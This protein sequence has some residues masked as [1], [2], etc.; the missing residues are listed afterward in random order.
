MSGRRVGRPSGRFE[1]DERNASVPCSLADS[2]ASHPDPPVPQRM[3]RPNDFVP[4]DLGRRP[5]FPELPSIAAE[6]LPLLVTGIA[7]VAGYQAFLA[8]RA[9]YGTAVFGQRRRDNRRLTGPGVLAFDLEDPV[10]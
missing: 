5:E 7:G 1:A 2:F 9:R 10:A 4:D 3:S 8:L 6:R